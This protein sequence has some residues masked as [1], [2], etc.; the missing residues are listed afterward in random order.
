MR[1]DFC[2]SQGRC[3]SGCECAKCIDPESYDQW[4]RNCHE[5]YDQW[6]EQKREEEEHETQYDRDLAEI[7]EQE[8]LDRL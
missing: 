5:E 2:F 4:K 3:Y 1:C 6:L 8:Y 7:E